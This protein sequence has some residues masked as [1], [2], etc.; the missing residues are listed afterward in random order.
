L[1]P[2]TIAAI[3]A[4]LVFVAPGL[5]FELLRERRRPSIEETAFREASRVALT[6]TLFSGIAL[7]ALF[8]LGAVR[9]GWVVDAPAWLNGGTDY[10][11][12]N[13]AVV[14]RTVG[15][16]AGLALIMVVAVD[17][18]LLRSP[19]GRIVAGSIWFSLFRRHLPE[20]ARPW[21][22]LR[23][24]DETEVWGYAGDYTPEQQLD[25][26]ELLVEAPALEYRRKGQKDSTP[27]PDWSFIAVRG[28]SI[29][30]MKVQY[31]KP[32][33]EGESLRVPARMDLERRHW[34]RAASPKS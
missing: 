14:T 5:A 25:N 30:W 7:L 16:F 21:L 6:S 2:Q 12:D 34:W 15:L 33:Q 10:V 32:G 3:G 28:E 27:L 22:H 11:A 26:R 4:F 1:I 9:P 18:A 31:I 13:V 17:L 24:I 19:S 20:G 23:L 8:A 29:V